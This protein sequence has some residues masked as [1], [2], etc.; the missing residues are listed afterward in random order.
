VPVSDLHIQQAYRIL[1]AMKTTLPV[2]IARKPNADK[3]LAGV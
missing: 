3:R 1:S 2:A